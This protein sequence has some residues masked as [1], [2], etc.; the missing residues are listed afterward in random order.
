[1]YLTNVLKT[2]LTRE[3]AAIEISNSVLEQWFGDSVPDRD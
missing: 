1:V 3:P 2:Q